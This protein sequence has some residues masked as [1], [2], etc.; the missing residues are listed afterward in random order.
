MRPSHNTTLRHPPIHK[1]ALSTTAQLTLEAQPKF[2]V[3]LLPVRES[4]SFV[5]RG[6]VQWNGGRGGAPVVCDPIG[7]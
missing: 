2:R 6:E 3:H 1:P 5:V 7:M 4:L